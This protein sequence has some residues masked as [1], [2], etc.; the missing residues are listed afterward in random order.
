MRDKNCNVYIRKTNDDIIVTHSTMNYYAYLI[1]VF[2]A[3]HFPTRDPNVG[4]ETVVFSSRPGDLNSKDDFYILSSG[5]KVVETSLYNYN[6]DNFKEL[7]PQSVPCWIRATAASN[8]ARNG[9]EW[10]SYF[11]KYNSGTHNNQ[12][13][14]VD[15]SQMKSNKNVVV[16]V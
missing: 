14:I 15:K 16:F 4:S 1:R 9:Q 12:W 3:Y 7:N 10:I 6:T 13:V 11:S 5:L 2:K 8:L